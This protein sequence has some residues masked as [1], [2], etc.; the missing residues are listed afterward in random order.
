MEKTIERLKALGDEN[1]F[2]IF[3]MLGNKS[4]CACEIRE[5]LGIAG[6]TLSVHLKILRSAGLIVQ[7]K[8]G[9]WIEFALNG[10]DP[11]I[12]ELKAFLAGRLT[13]DTSVLEKD[14][15]VAQTTTRDKIT[16]VG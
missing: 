15:A 3:M 2:R 11:R 5:V 8:N 1:R 4:M 12:P 16:A 6:S 13:E 7:K 14:R 9:R 10:K